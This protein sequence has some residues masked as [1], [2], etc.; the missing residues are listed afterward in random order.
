[1]QFSSEELTFQAKTAETVKCPIIDKTVQTT[2]SSYLGSLQTANQPLLKISW[3]LYIFGYRENYG[4][5]MKHNY[6]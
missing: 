5:K 4:I 1:V 3:C 6:D 2:N